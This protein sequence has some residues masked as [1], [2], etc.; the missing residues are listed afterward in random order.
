MS[1]VYEQPGS[2]LTRLKGIPR[3]PCPAS[4]KIM[5]HLLARHTVLELAQMFEAGFHTITRW[6]RE[7]GLP[8][9]R[10]RLHRPQNDPGSQ[11]Q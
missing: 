9:R 4:P 6:R 8:Q 2:I 3:R 7:L 1:S 10:K 5:R 11:G